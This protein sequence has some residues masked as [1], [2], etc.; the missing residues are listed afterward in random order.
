GCL[1]KS[2]PDL[3][4]LCNSLHLVVSGLLRWKRDAVPS[5]AQ[6][7]DTEQLYRH[8]C[9]RGRRSMVFQL[10]RGGRNCDP[11]CPGTLRPRWLR[12]IADQRLV[13]TAVPLRD[14]FSTRGATPGSHCSAL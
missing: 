10:V 11:H 12:A 4:F 3:A 8:F 7:L 9:P 13:E 14:R 5:M 6:L 1:C 2:F